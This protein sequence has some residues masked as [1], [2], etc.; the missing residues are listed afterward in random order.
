MHTARE[1]ERERQTERGTKQT[2]RE[3]DGSVRIDPGLVMAQ[4]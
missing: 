3:M 2:D 4:S 1:R